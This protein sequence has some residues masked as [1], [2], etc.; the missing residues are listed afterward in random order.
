[1]PVR[2]R[3]AL[4]ASVSAAMSASISLFFTWLSGDFAKLGQEV[5]AKDRPVVVE[6]GRLATEG[7][8]VAEHQVSG[9][10][11]RDARASCR[12]SLADH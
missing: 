1:M 2:V 11:E 3:A 9:A 10:R 12:R 6:G 5:R 7:L 8:E 4:P